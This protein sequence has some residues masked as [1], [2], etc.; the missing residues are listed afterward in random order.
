MIRR[1]PRSTRTAPLFPCTTL[2]RPAETSAGRGARR[3]RWRATRPACGTSAKA[4]CS[5]PAIVAER[6]AV[7]RGSVV[8][9][10]QVAR[11]QAQAQA[12]ARHGLALGEIDLDHGPVRQA[13]AAD[14]ARPHERP[15]QQRSEEHTSALQSIM[16]N[17]YDVFCLIKK[18]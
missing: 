3:R 9:L 13:Q 11:V 8:E 2:F 1:P 18:N 16:R 4:V 12:V 10:D 5:G 7:R 6:A 17:S 14:A 15:R